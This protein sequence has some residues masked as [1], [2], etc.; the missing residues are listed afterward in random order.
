MALPGIRGMCC[1]MDEH[2]SQLVP[3]A[4]ST[5]DFRVQMGQARLIALLLLAGCSSV[6][7]VERAWAQCLAYGGSPK[8]MVAGELRQAEC[9]REQVLNSAQ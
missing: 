4:H 1:S 7:D 2:P 9:K 6:P 5:D 8:F 3:Q